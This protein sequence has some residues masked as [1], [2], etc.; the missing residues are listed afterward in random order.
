MKKTVSAKPGT[1]SDHIPGVKYGFEARYEGCK[2]P[3]F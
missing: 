1:P 2:R 3:R